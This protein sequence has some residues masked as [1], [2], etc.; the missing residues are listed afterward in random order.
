MGGVRG[1]MKSHSVSRER[2]KNWARVT[3][4]HKCQGQDQPPNTTGASSQFLISQ[5]IIK[6]Y[7]IM[8]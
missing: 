4:C 6:D 1:V 8:L 7:H 3:R 5:F 2:H